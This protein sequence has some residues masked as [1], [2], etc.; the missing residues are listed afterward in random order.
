VTGLGGF[1]NFG[2]FLLEIILL[3][4]WA[5]FIKNVIYGQNLC[6]VV[7]GAEDLLNFFV[8]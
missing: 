1:S 5:T 2:Q 8:L 7:A 6:I 3:E 4:I